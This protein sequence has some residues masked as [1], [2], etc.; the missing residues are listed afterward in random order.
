MENSLQRI[1]GLLLKFNKR[2]TFS[3]TEVFARTELSIL[4]NFSVIAGSDWRAGTHY[5]R[6][7]FNGIMSYNGFLN[8]CQN[9]I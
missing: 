2:L 4:T 8:A 6:R 7:L 3:I 1:F 5:H 9:F